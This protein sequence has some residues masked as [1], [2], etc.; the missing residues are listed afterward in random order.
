MEATLGIGDDA[1]TQPAAYHLDDAVGD[2]CDPFEIMGGEHD[3]HTSGSR[4][5]DQIIDELSTVWVKAGVR[6]V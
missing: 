6:L 1:G 5:G 2:R 4:L 3:G